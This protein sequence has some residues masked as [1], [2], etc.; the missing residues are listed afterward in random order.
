M[1]HANRLRKRV[2]GDDANI[3]DI[4]VLVDFIEPHVHPHELEC[5]LDFHEQRT[6]HH[7]PQTSTR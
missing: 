6:R 5:I 1:F 4:G 3:V 2:V 7:C